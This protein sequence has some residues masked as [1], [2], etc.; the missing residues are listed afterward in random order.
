MER[1]ESKITEFKEI[2]VP[3]DLASRAIDA[4]TV[5]VC[6]PHSTPLSIWKKLTFI[7]CYVPR[8]GHQDREF[9]F[10]CED[11]VPCP[12]CGETRW[13]LQFVTVFMNRPLPPVTIGLEE[14]NP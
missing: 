7:G 14:F 13:F 3:V 4:A 9:G 10:D 2:G 8:C 1:H 11:V 5:G 12:E 6:A